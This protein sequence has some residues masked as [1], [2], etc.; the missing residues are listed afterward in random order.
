MEYPMVH[1]SSIV[2]VAQKSRGHAS[3]YTTSLIMSAKGGIATALRPYFGCLRGTSRLL[4]NYIDQHHDDVMA[5]YQRICA[6]QKGYPY[7]PDVAAKIAA[8][9]QRAQTRLAAI[10]S[11]RLGEQK[12]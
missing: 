4:S 5:S 9:L 11:S 7:T 1:R 3:P 12:E 2:V 6:R 10:K 8:S